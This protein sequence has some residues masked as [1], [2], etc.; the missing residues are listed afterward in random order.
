M[1]SRLEI[2]FVSLLVV[3]GA[4]TGVLALSPSVPLNS[5]S[6]T[7][8]NHGTNCYQPTTSFSLPISTSAPNA[9]V[10]LIVQ[11][12]TVSPT[13]IT[14]TSGLTW[15]GPFTNFEANGDVN[16]YWAVKANAGPTTISGVMPDS[17]HFKVLWFDVLG[18]NLTSPFDANPSLPAN[19]GPE[20][21]PTMSVTAST[22]TPNDFVFSY[23]TQV[24]GATST[25]TP[26][27]NSPFALL[28]GN[29]NGCYSQAAWL[30]YF[31]ASTTQTSVAFEPM[32]FTLSN[33]VAGFVA[34]IQGP[35]SGT[36]TSNSS[37]TSSGQSSSDDTSTVTSTITTTVTTTVTVSSSATTSTTVTSSCTVT[38]T[39]VGQK[40]VGWQ[41]SC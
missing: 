22:S 21:G 39:M 5:A 36:T 19:S 8:D 23:V 30:A 1:D 18:A 4:V 9:L 16:L 34:A 11:L 10:V 40:V 25:N 32:T 41:G 37:T 13:S 2:I 15:N 17:E 14:D 20:A 6:P 27:V 3:A 12:N 33:Q 7:L 28:D 38:F 31:D 35:S 24:G 29:N 26:T